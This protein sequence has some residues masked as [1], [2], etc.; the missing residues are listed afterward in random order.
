MGK[1]EYP[2]EE[3]VSL[4]YSHQEGIEWVPLRGPIDLNKREAVLNNF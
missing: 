4:I 2:N 3:Q 1:I